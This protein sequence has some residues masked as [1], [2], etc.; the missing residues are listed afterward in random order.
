VYCRC[1]IL[2]R[3]NRNFARPDRAKDL[4]GVLGLGES[5][6]RLL[7]PL[8]FSAAF[9][10][11]S[12]PAH[13]C[14]DKLLILGRPLHFNARSAAILA[15][16]PPGS[17]VEM[18]LNGSQWT[19]AMAKGRHRL[20]IVQTTEQ[21]EKILKAERFD[22]VVA[23]SA[24][25]TALLPELAITPFPT[26]FVP[27]VSSSSREVFR[28]VEKEYDVAMKDPANTGEYLAAIGRAVDLHDRRVEAAAR[29]KKSPSKSS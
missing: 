12:H 9:L 5:M 8:F 16:A 6:Q 24:H 7:F 14:G 10:L 18:M 20:R 13:T 1:H 28:A 15:F 25:A 19:A 17:S 22:V 26:V 23:D 11:V 3:P 4:K 21:L 27:V 2:D 29:K